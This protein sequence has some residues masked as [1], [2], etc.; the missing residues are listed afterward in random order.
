MIDIVIVNWNSRDYLFN[1]IKSLREL[2]YTPNSFPVN[3]VIV[4]DNYSSDQSF[5]KIEEFKDLIP[6]VLLKNQSNTGFAAACNQG[7]KYSESEFILFLNPDTELFPDTLESSLSFMRSKFCENNKIGICGIQLVDSE[8][9]VTPSCSR[10]PMPSRILATNFGINRLFPKF[11]DRELMTDFNHLE[12]LIVD[13]V[14]GAFF[15]VRKSLYN[16]LQGFDERF[17][18]YYEE[19]DFSLRAKKEGFSSCFFAEAKIYHKGCGTTDSVSGLALFYFL[20]SR[21]QYLFKNHNLFS[22]ILVLLFAVTVEPFSRSLYSISK[23]SFKD[24]KS[25]SIAY[26]YLYK[27]LLFD[28]SRKDKIMH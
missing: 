12:T 18:V 9:K 17:F 25:T 15:M 8:L 22:A 21:T 11:F 13:Q 2:A 14:K 10:F 16:S 26:T 6:L 7:A 5:E 23:M 1:C 19:V 4:V 3:K 20:R 28:R 24:L 27:W